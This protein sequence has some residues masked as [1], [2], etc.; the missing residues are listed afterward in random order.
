MMKVN[1]CLFLC[2]ISF[3]LCSCEKDASNLVPVN[4][5]IVVNSFISPQDLILKVFV[6]VSSP[7]YQPHV[8]GSDNSSQLKNALV[9]ISDGSI[10]KQLIWNDL[11]KDF[12]LD[13]NQFPILVGKTYYLDVKTPDGR[14]VSA[15][16][17]IPSPVLNPIFDF[18]GY[19]T[20]SVS[21]ANSA[22]VRYQISDDATVLNYYKFFT[23]IK[24]FDAQNK[25]VSIMSGGE[26]LQSDKNFN[27]NI[28]E[29]TIQFIVYNYDKT[30]T[31][32]KYTGYFIACNKDYYEF[33]KTLTMA[34]AGSTTPFSEYTQVYSNIK[35]GLGVFAG[36]NLKTI[37]K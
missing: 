37:E 12:E 20:N 8:Y 10:K 2:F 18:L 13:Q 14:Q 21:G 11:N 9:F 3:T 27:G 6:N 22:L 29:N 25:N 15:Q 34:N 5:K 32:E 28:F 1:T 33:Y 4:E 31:T 16:T 30:Q 23:E 17:T 35:G 24:G 26:E 36:Y 19:K 7:Y